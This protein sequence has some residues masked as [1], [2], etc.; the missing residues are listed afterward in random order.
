[1]L[2]NTFCHIPRLGLK[3]E[4]KLWEAGFTTWRAL[5]DADDAPVRS[6]GL[7][8][9]KAHLAE[10]TARLDA[11]DAAYFAQ[12]LPG[13]QHWRL[14][15]AF[16][17]STAYLDI[18]TTGL[19]PPDDHIT[20]IAIWDG[21]T[22][23]TFVHGRNLDDFPAAIQDYKL[24]VTFNGRCFD[25]PFIERAFGI[26]LEQPHMDLRFILKAV[27][28][29]GG[30]KKC[31]KHLGLD[32]GVLEGVDGYYAVLLWKEFL[33]TG[34]ERFLQ[35]LVAYNVEDVLNLEP[36]A[37]AAYNLHLDTTPFTDA[38]RLPEPLPQGNPIPAHPDTIAFIRRKYFG[39]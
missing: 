27:G 12:R 32:R 36:L 26:R 18:E 21:R 16:R 14:F 35:T 10:S 7:D 19:T 1:M 22:V 11:A 13:Q 17:H 33:E 29:T 28:I 6:P 24:L 34:D 25:V 38:P 39:M 31:E 4:A 5:L 15:P 20:S 9:M 8:W 2:A 30:L 3:S 23:Q 37:V